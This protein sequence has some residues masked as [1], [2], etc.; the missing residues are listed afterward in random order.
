MATNNIIV[1]SADKS[2]PSE[3]LSEESGAQNNPLKYRLFQWLRD[4]PTQRKRG[5][6]RKAA[7]ALH[8]DYAK[9]K[10]ILWNY[11][12]LFK[13]DIRASPEFERHS[14]S[15]VCSKPD[16]QHAVFA[17]AFVPDCL[18][19]HKYSEVEQLAIEAGWRL[20]KNRNRILIWNHPVLFGKEQVFI[21]RIQWWTT[22]L[23]RIHVL[24]PQNL[25]RAKQLVYNA[26]VTTGLINNL[27]ISEELLDSIR[28]HDTHDVYVTDHNLPYKKITTYSELGVKAIKMGDYSH[29]NCLEVEVVKPDIV[30]KYEKF[31]TQV[32]KI[33]E[34]HEVK[35]VKLVK[36]LEA[37]SEAIQQFNAYLREVSAPKV[38][39]SKRLYE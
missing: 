10:K 8:I 5:F 37:N 3:V 26:F 31:V 18:D 1:H 23:V 16:S 2:Y 7:V 38:Q 12:S 24:K 17:G 19:R 39:G 22:S 13:T 25:G 33:L 29:R 11:S 14:K 15:G 27:V 30:G 4:N 28:W 21:G 35:D 36:I 20:S 6:L 32:T 34:Q 9:N